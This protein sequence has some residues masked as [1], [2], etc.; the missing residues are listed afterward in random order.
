MPLPLNRYSSLN[1]MAVPVASSAVVS[2]PR[3]ARPEHAGEE[4]R[5]SVHAVGA[6]AEIVSWLP[7][8]AATVHDPLHSAA[9]QWLPRMMS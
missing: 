8:G 7:N 1:Y 9:Q 5:D 4:A 3:R 2:S 6:N